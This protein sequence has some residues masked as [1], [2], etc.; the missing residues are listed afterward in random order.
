MVAQ[1]GIATVESSTAVPKKSYLQLPSDSAVHVCAYAPTQRKAGAWGR[2]LHT[3]VHRSVSPKV[4]S[5]PTPTEGQ[6]EKQTV[7]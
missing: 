5:N 3:P 1:S 4:G 6:M 7:V 2:Y